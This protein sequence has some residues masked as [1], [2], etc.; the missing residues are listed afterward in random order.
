MGVPTGTD[1][2]QLGSNC[3]A[4]PS[5]RSILQQGWMKKK[6][7][8]REALKLRYVVLTETDEGHLQMDYYKD[9]EKS[10]WQGGRVFTPGTSNQ[11]THVDPGA[12]RKPITITTAN[13][14][15]ELTVCNKQGELSY[16]QEVDKWNK[17]F[18]DK[19][20]VKWD[21]FVAEDAGPDIVVDREGKRASCKREGST[22]RA[23]DWVPTSSRA[24][25]TV[26]HG[27]G[28]GEVGVIV[29]E[30]TDMD[31]FVGGTKHGWGYDHDGD[32]YHN[33]KPL[34][35]DLQP[36]QKND[37]ITIDVHN[38]KLT[39]KVNGIV[40]GTPIDLPKNT[41]MAMAVSLCG[42]DGAVGKASI[43]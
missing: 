2:R 30:F 33:D 20:V 42:D 28:E 5:E 25:G 36:L 32:I 27:G 17:L 35:E 43:V 29:S 13:R 21:R 31:E 41:K 15:W 40:Q 38:G 23:G 8:R 6:G 26:R 24:T 7:Y 37:K 39:F 16:G 3:V 34:Q 12:Q 19:K 11:I 9:E 4:A 1:R 14:V 22:V 10:Q 18:Q